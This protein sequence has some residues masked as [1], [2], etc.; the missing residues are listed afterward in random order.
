[1]TKTNKLVASGIVLISTVLLIDHYFQNANFPVFNPTGAIGI[2]QRNIMFQALFLSLFVVI[3]VFVLTLFITLKY[4]E[5]NLKA[6]YT[7]D[8]DHNRLIETIWWGIPA[9]L[10]V[11]LSVITWNSSHQL[12]PARAI[13]SSNKTIKIQVVALQWKWL[14]IYPEQQI[15]SVNFLQIP[16]DTPINF[17]ITADAP[18]NSFWIPSLGGQIYAMPGMS[19]HLNLIANEAGS[20]RG[21]SANLSGAGF[22]N[23]TFTTR[24]TSRAEF[25]DWAAST[26]RLNT[27]FTQSEYDLLAVPSNYKKLA[28]YAMNDSGLYDRV[29]MKYMMPGYSPMTANPLYELTNKA[30]Y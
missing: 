8:W 15:A 24:A 23:M 11:I 13:S 14:F 30:A 12:D 17:E 4:R 25:D 2:S 3:P 27:T 26:R 6:K 22:S 19:T 1:M 21:S 7:P 28:F 5:T 20:F 29:V 9:I 18:M 10:I 16:T